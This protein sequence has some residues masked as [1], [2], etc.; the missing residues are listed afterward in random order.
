MSSRSEQVTELQGEEQRCLDKMAA[1]TKRLMAE[2]PGLPRSAAFARA[3][4]ELPNCYQTYCDTRQA[5]AALGIPPLLYRD[6]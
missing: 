6:L 5:L 2:T 3:I 4:A 1:R